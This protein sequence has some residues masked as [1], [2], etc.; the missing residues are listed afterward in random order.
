MTVAMIGHL[1]RR[2]AEANIFNGGKNNGNDNVFSGWPVA[3]FAV[4]AVTVVFY[5][6][7][8]T[9]VSSQILF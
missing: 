9:V 3:L 8:A 5:V 7:I 4:F 6:I 2:G 1:V